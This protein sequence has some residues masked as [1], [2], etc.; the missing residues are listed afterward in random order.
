[1]VPTFS[2]AW[3]LSSRSWHMRVTWSVFDLLLRKPACSLGSCGSI[4]GLR[5]VSLGVIAWL[6]WLWQGD[7]LG[8]APDLWQL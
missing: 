4:T 3:K 1:M 6:V 5:P 8:M 2:P 7:H